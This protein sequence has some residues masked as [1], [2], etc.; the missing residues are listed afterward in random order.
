MKK[1]RREGDG[2]RERRRG[3]CGPGGAEVPF[4]RSLCVKALGLLNFNKVVKLTG[5]RSPATFVSS[6]T[7]QT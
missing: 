7:A 1:Q 4:R 2:E 3:A 6:T 5:A